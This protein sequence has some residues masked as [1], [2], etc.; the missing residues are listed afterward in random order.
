M[1]KGEEEDT[2]KRRHKGLK[3]HTITT[4]TTTTCSNGNYQWRDYVVIAWSE[5]ELNWSELRVAESSKSTE[6]PLMMV[7]WC[8]LESAPE[9][10]IRSADHALLFFAVKAMAHRS[11]CQLP[12]FFPF[13]HLK[14]NKH[15]SQEERRMPSPVAC[16]W[17]TSAAANPQSRQ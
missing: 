5:T 7:F 8:A 14:A 13:C 11:D 1:E 16:W 12:L 4:T 17:S 6:K 9:R 10:L 2:V 15:Q 3:S